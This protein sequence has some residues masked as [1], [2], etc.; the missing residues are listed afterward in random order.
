VQRVYVTFHHLCQRGIY[1]TVPRQGR[2]AGEL[3]GHDLKLVMTSAIA[4]AGVPRVLV[5]VI[6]DLDLRGL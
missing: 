1:H 4:R 2:L 6:S 3:R 5:A